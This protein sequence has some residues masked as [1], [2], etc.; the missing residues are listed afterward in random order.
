MKR[1]PWTSMVNKVI[2]LKMAVIDEW[3]KENADMIADV[4]SPERLV[5][6]PYEQWKDNQLVLQQLS[7]I[8][9]TEEPNPLSELIYRKSIAE[10]RELEGQR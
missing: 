4:G 5:G 2:E 8:Y 9:G 6:A 7:R 1:E 3:V 10:V